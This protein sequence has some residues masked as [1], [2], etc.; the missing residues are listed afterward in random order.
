MI[1]ERFTIIPAIDLKDGQ[2]VRLRQGLIDRPTVYQTDPAE[3]ARSFAQDG[4]ELI[5]VVDLDGAVAGVPRNLQAIQ[6]IRQV[7]SCY[8]EFSGG[9]RTIESVREALSAGAD[10]ISIGSAAILDPD[11]LK[12]TCAELPGRV[13][14]SLDIRD[15]QMVIKGWLEGSSLTATEGVRRFDEAGVTALIVTDVS[16]DGTE[17]GSNAEF[18]AEIARASNRPIIASGGVGDLDDVRALKRC[19]TDGVVG[20]IIGRAL[21]ERRFTL[22]EARAVADGGQ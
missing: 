6:R 4:A 16:R 9:L 19:F 15:G 7:T 8:I 21:Y 13:F 11:F 14:G 2:V 1:P 12:R 5:H 22:H 20:V 3:V 10:F 18:F 17:A